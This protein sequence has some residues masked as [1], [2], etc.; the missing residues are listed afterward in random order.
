MAAP[1]KKM[2]QIRQILTLKNEGLGTRKITRQTQFSRNT[3]RDYLQRAAAT[4]QSLSILLALDN[5]A[6]STALGLDVKSVPVPD[7]RLAALEGRFEYFKSELRK[8]GV[9]RLLL[10]E[11]YI[12]EQTDGYSYTQ[13][14]THF[15]RYLDVHS[16]VIHL[17]HS[18]A[19]VLMVDF[20]GDCLCRK[21]GMPNFILASSEWY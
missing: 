10:W 1:T 4:G 17:N 20:A 12:K 16:A 3:V 9:T 5:D 6:L 21:A 8:T 13:F 18:P 11:E 15:R 14:C 19:E 2:H 7:S